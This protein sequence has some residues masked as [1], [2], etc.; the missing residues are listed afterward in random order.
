MKNLIHKLILSA[1][2]LLA[3]VVLGSCSKET[4]A[5]DP[6]DEPRS[7]DRPIELRGMFG[8]EKESAGPEYKAADGE[9]PVD[10]GA[11]TTPALTLWFARADETS[12]G[13]WGSYASEQ[14]YATRP[15]AA[16][17]TPAALAFPDPQ[18]CYLRGLKAKL[19]GWYPGGGASDSPKGYW[20]GTSVTWKMDGRHDIMTA[21]AQTGDVVSGLSAFVF[22]HR[23]AQLRFYVYAETDKVAAL[24]GNIIA[25]RV[26]SQA[27]ACTYTPASGDETGAVAFT[28]SSASFT[29]LSGNVRPTVT[30][31]KGSVAQ[32]GDAVMIAPQA[33]SYL[34]NLAVETEQQGTVSVALPG[35]AYDEAG[36]YNIYLKLQAVDITPAV[37]ISDWGAVVEKDIEL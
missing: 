11:Q 5:A 17:D 10:G 33:G 12:S 2:L 3:A 13:V 29:A 14:L 16:G 31:N 35:R 6:G 25:I 19:T 1:G 18:P 21:S 37:D 4:P 34:L 24:W 30:T 20:N 32:A 22:M 28:G 8:P 15:A 36:T 26:L 23:T 27:D 9:G 7:T